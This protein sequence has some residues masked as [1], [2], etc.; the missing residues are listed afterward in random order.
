MSR[1]ELTP[2]ITI[3]ISRVEDLLREVAETVVLPLYGHSDP[4]EKAP[5]DWVTRADRESE[6]FLTRHLQQLLPGALVVGEEATSAD[7]SVTDRLQS[8]GPV[9]VIDP[10]DGTAN[11]VSGEGPFAV[12]AA[13]VIDGVTVAGW[14]YL[15]VAEEMWFAQ[16]GRGASL[17]GELRPPLGDRTPPWRGPMPPTLATSNPVDL[18]RQPPT[19]SAGQDYPNI[20]LDMADFA[21][22]WGTA[23]WDHAAG[24]LIVEESGGVVARLDGTA[25]QVR[26][27]RR[28]G[29]LVAASQEVW[30]GV[31]SWLPQDL[32]PGPAPS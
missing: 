11:Y 8:P 7:P 19:G 26:E 16:K 20:C 32:I 10:I 3:A 15:P 6:E 4:E 22:F 21:P 17:N 5:G 31:R 12:M 30:D 23:P 27:H 1:P 14:I 29:L 25:F 28:P 2:E 24:A 9:W 13:L 18:H